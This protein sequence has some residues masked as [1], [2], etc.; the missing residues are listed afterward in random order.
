MLRALSTRLEQWEVQLAARRRSL[1]SPPST[2]LALPQAW[3]DL[4]REL[5]DPSL[6]RIPL[7]RLE[8]IAARLLLCRQAEQAMRDAERAW[9]AL[10]PR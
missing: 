9:G 7:E 3:L 6:N 1:P 4:N 10:L 8:R 5:A 2:A